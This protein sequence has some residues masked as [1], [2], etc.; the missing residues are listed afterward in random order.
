MTEAMQAYSGVTQ[1]SFMDRDAAKNDQIPKFKGVKGRIDRIAIVDPN[2]ILVGR[3]HSNFSDDKDKKGLGYVLCRSEYERQGDVEVTKRAALCC[4]MLPDATKRCATMVIHY[5]TDVKGKPV[6]TPETVEYT[7]KAWNF[8]AEKFQNLADINE[9]FAQRD[10]DGKVTVPGLAL[11]DLLITC[12]DEAWQRIKIVP[13]PQCVRNMAP[14]VAKHAESIA[15]VVKAFKPRLVR[16]IGRDVSDQ[17]LIEKLGGSG[18]GSVSAPAI[19][20]QAAPE[21]IQALFGT[22]PF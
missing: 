12:E 9:E 4:Q 18:S 3:A 20:P 21:D 7:L 11:V 6:G 14:F 10:A 8:T 16:T 19:K 15:S 2:F 17:D 1:T 22:D 5:A 13:T